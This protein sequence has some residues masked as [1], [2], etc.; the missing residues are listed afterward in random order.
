[1]NCPLFRRKRREPLGLVSLFGERLNLDE[2]PPRVFVVVEPRNPEDTGTIR[3]RRVRPGFMGE[4]LLQFLGLALGET[5]DFPG[6][7]P[8]VG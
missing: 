7:L 2:M 3:C 6:R 4:T 5:V 8:F 1:M